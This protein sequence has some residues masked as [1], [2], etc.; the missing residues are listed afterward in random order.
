MAE[1]QTARGTL[2]DA[3]VDAIVAFLGS[4]EGKIPQDKIEPPELP[5]DGPSTPAPDPA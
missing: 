1:H 3:E 2:A 5:P 4:L